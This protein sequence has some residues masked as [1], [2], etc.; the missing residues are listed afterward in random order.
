MLKTSRE[1]GRRAI[2]G[3]LIACV[4]TSGAQSKARNAGVDAQRVDHGSI[5]IAARAVASIAAKARTRALPL[6]GR[7]G[8]P[9]PVRPSTA[10]AASASSGWMRVVVV[11]I[12]TPAAI[13]IVPQLEVEA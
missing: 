10:P 6:N 7:Q 4:Q 9:M 11:A 5:N 12:A 8:W 2:A 1:S 13:R 3:R